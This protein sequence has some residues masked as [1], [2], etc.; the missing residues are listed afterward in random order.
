[1]NMM[2]FL[3]NIIMSHYVGAVFGILQ[4]MFPR[5]MLDDGVTSNVAEVK[6]LPAQ[7]PRHNNKRLTTHFL[8]HA[9]LKLTKPTQHNLIVL[10]RNKTLFTSSKGFFTISMLESGFLING[11]YITLLSNYI[12]DA[13]FLEKEVV[14][15]NLRIFTITC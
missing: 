12:H 9:E 8:H 13:L 2:I 10:V 7:L 14:A 11:R 3:G 4:F 6:L 1:M 15:E 5:V